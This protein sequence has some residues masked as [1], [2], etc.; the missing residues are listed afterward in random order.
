MS[1]PDLQQPSTD[2]GSPP[3]SARNGSMMPH[4]IA[5]TAIN[6]FIDHDD[7]TLAASIAYYTALS[8]APLL[9]LGLWLAASVSPNAQ[10]ELIAQIGL[11]AGND[12]QAAVQ[13]IIENAS[14]KPS[15]G[16][17]AG[18]IG[19]GVLVFSA[20]A[21]FSQLQG[22]LNVI[23]EVDA[24]PRTETTYLLLQ[25]L[26]RRMLSIG[27]LAAV[28]FVLMVS[29]VVSA[30]LGMLLPKEG[31]VWDMAT[32]VITTIVFTVLFAALFKYLPDARLSWRHTVFGALITALLFTAGKY[33]IGAYLA[34]SGVGG[35]YGPAG[36]L[37]V[38]LVWVFY[39]AAI[40]LFGA[41]IVQAIATARGVRTAQKA[42]A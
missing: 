2:A 39:S 18:L 35:S 29:L 23:L 7:L 8:L 1:L 38:L 22:A 33:G 5:W 12:A 13:L 14:S 9:V 30:V 25:W 36:S 41:E 37:V 21:V 24:P 31:E 42:L 32:Q 40:F 6:G 19:I 27:I 34:N 3:A 17:F 4:R 11:L 15:A 10:A 20:T 26:R 28:T 16:S